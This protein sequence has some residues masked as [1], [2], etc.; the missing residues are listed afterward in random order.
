MNP[1]ILVTD[2]LSCRLQ[3]NQLLPQKCSTRSKFFGWL[4]DANNC[5]E[6]C[7]KELGENEARGEGNR[8]GYLTRK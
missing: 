3:F 5:A 7:K 4:M 2:C 1:E 6:D 8:Q